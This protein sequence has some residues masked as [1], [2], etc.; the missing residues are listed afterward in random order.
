MRG[1]E[2]SSGVRRVLR[3][4]AV[5]AFVTVGAAFAAGVGAASRAPASIGEMS[6]PRIHLATPI[7]PQATDGMLA[8]GP[9]HY[10]DTNMP[11]TGHGIVAFAGHRVTPVGGR[12]YG[13]FRYINVL[14]RGDAISITR[15]YSGRPMTF[16]YVVYR[17]EVVRPTYV[18]WLGEDPS[19]ETLVLSSCTPPGTATYRIL[20]FAHRVA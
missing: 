7:Y 11:G 17:T 20:V 15:T 13:P 9:G 3:A 6:I 19:V 16:R 1:I 18:S 10:A 4:C 14:R 5:V 12:P 8:F 2:R